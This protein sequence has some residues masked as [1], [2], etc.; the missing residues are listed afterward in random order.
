MRKGH[1]GV[2]PDGSHFSVGLV[3]D[4]GPHHLHSL[5]KHWDQTAKRPGFSGPLSPGWILVG[6]TW[7]SGQTLS[8]I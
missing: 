1:L 5:S 2:G 6:H 7:L 8:L 4:G 3:V